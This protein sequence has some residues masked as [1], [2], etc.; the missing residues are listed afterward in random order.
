MK[1]PTLPTQAPMRG[2]PFT[3]GSF[4][5]LSLRSL[6]RLAGRE[7]RARDIG[8]DFRQVADAAVLVDHAGLFAAGRAVANEFHEFLLGIGVCGIFSERAGE[9][10]AVDQKILSGDI[11]GLRR[12]EEGASRAKLVGRAEA[13]VPE[14]NSMLRASASS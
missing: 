14:P 9:S 12:A 8:D 7:R 10:A 1:L 6:F 2:L 13:A 4:S 5:G 11:A 3:S